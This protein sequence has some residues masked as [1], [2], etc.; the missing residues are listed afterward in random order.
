[1]I[2]K[3]CSIVPKYQV[4]AISISKLFSTHGLSPRS[5]SLVQ[6]LS[7]IWSR[8]SSRREPVFAR[9]KQSHEVNYRGL[10]SPVGLRYRDK[11]RREK[12]RDGAA[13]I[14]R[15]Y[16][17][18]DSFSIADFHHCL[19]LQMRFLRSCLLAIIEIPRVSSRNTIRFNACTTVTKDP[20]VISNTPYLEHNP[21]AH[22]PP[23]DFPFPSNH[24]L[25]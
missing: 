10:I 15:V 1:M 3:Y 4:I 9:G 2:T 5:A 8:G 12:S 7:E 14:N 21:N 17:S 24:P 16:L 11:E 20:N 13:S 22:F 25:L 19:C 6:N 18:N 23:I